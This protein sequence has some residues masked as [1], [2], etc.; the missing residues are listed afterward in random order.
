MIEKNSLFYMAN[1]YPEVNRMLDFYDAGKNE[2]AN[3]AK[4]RALNI[5]DQIL[6]YKDIKPGGR[7]EWNVIKN[8]VLGFDKLDD[9]EKTIL[10]KYAE[11]FSFKFMNQYSKS[12]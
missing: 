9:Y 5:L 12:N 2:A 11:P 10:K 3:N 7:E 8:F 4:T 6:S 1:F